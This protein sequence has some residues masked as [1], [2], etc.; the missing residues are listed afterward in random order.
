[1]K[2]NISIAILLIC[3]TA[4]NTS[5]SKNSKASP[6]ELAKRKNT[7]KTMVNKALAF[8]EKNGKDKT[9]EELNKKDGQFVIN[10]MYVFAYTNKGVL[11]ANPLNKQLL[12]NDLSNWIDSRGKFFRQEMIEKTKNSGSG[13]ITYVYS[14]PKTK[15][16]RDKMT[17]CKG[18][19][20]LILC[21]GLYYKK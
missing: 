18:V 6:G 21:S 1:M 4:L 14:H 17:Y 12:G 5:C 8:Y 16:V 9:I 3:M 19:D 2:K 11:I 10:D 7:A 20:D 15:E 13:W